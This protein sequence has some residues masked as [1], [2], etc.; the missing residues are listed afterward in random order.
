MKQVNSTTFAALGECM[1]ELRH[2][3]DLTLKLGFAGDTYNV[4]T[5]LARYAPQV[6]TQVSYVT[7]VGNDPYS[8]QM[9][10]RWRQDNINTALIPRLPQMPGLY[11]IRTDEQGERSFYYYREQSAAREMLHGAHGK[12]ICEELQQFNYIY[13]SGISLAIIDTASQQL[14]LETIIA[15]RKKGARIIF[16]TNY[17]PKLWKSHAQAQK[18]ILEFLHH[19]DIA[20]PTF[21]DERLLFG[22]ATPQDSITRLQQLGVEEI[23]V[24][25]GDKPCLV[26]ANGEVTPVSAS[27]VKSIVD[28]TSAGDSFNAAYIAARIKGL[29]PI[30]AAECGHQLASL[31]IQHPGAIMPA[32]KMPSLF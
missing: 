16:D 2:Q 21:D 14:L 31:V 13:F 24:K 29:K 26:I 7:A 20:L 5:Y 11:L 3:D 19:V 17:R 4:A 8:V 32:D 27:K 25:I 23:A 12:K 15:A 18:V 6:D 22:D 28:T 9:L 30:E 10:N 1:I